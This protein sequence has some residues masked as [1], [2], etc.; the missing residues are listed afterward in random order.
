[1][2]LERLRILAK[3]SASLVLH[4]YADWRIG[5]SDL[6]KHCYKQSDS[7][8]LTFDDYG[9][10]E[11]VHD[12]LDILRR[13]QIKAAFFLQGDWAQ[14]NGALIAEIAQAGHVVGN[15][16]VTH[17]VLTKLPLSNVRTE[18]AGGLPGPWFRP[19]QGRYNKAI[20]KLAASLGYVICYWT[21]DSRDWTG[22]SASEMRHTILSEL[23]PGATILFHLHGAHTRELLPGI[24][25]D[26]RAQ[27]Y[28]LTSHDEA[29]SSGL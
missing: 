8:L 25:D 4:A 27:G 14:D 17:P 16:T 21:I 10:P 11:Q 9:T 28:R 12:I 6:E 3:H 20:R 1:M 7:V 22:A 23:A 15:H 24:I 5:A 29:W 26:I 13:E 18:I 2:S 19:P